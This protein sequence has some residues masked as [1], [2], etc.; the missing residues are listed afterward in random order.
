MINKRRITSKIFPVVVWGLLAIWGLVFCIILLWAIMTSL[1]S[2]AD[3]F[4]NPYGFPHA[5]YFKNYADAMRTVKV[6]VGARTV[7][8]W[9]MFLNSI[10]YAGGSAFFAVLTSCLASYCVCKYSKYR[11][12]RMFWPIVLITNYL[13]V[14]SSIAGN[15][16][17]LTDLHLYDNVVGLWIWQS[18]AFGA[19]FLLYYATWKGVSWGYAEAAQIDGAGPFRIFLL[20]ML[21]LTR[22]IF[23]VLFLQTFIGLWNDYLTPIL[24]LPSMP[25]A[26]FGIW[27]FQ[28]DVSSAA[29][30]ITVRVAGLIVMLLPILVLF[31]IFTDKLMGS[32]TL[33]GLKG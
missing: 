14:S 33:G 17:F 12:V 25:T 28:Y 6:I 15:I 5:L 11:L 19:M 30:S 31:L 27:Q 21:P 13:P 2:R 18:V 3:F 22:T 32:L 24:Y 20:V 26:A 29:S 23:G 1:K 4:E 8:Y 16:K 7:G 10:L 9:E